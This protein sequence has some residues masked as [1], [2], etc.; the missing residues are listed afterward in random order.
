MCKHRK[1]RFLAYCHEKSLNICSSNLLTVFD[2]KGRTGN[3]EHGEHGW[4]KAGE[5]SYSLLLKSKAV[6]LLAKSYPDSSRAG[7][8]YQL[9][10]FLEF[11]KMGPEEFLGLSDLEIKQCVRR[12]CLQKNSEGS[13]AAGRRVFYVVRRFLELNDREVSFSKS[14]RETLIKRRPKKIARQ[15]IPTREDIYRMTDSYPDK[16]NNQQLRGRAI[17]LCGWQSGVRPSCLCSWTYGMFKDKLWPKPKIPIPI[18]VV[19]YRPPSVT[20]C[21]ED[22]KLS[23]YN[24]NYYYTFL[25]EEATQA[26]KAYL[27]ARIEGGWQ[28]RPEDPV[29]VTEGTVSR[30]K[31]LESRHLLEI[32]KNAAKQIGIDPSSIWTHCLRK[33]FR[34]TLYRG[35]VDPDVAEALMGHKLPGSRGSY[36]DYHDLRFVREEYLR[37]LWGRIDM[38]R[39]RELEEDV[40]KLRREK[41]KLE[42]LTKEVAE[43]R[44]VVRNLLRK[45]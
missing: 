18:K 41:K 29:F 2:L 32:V 33:A 12:A 11:N 1:I 19:A 40:G 5:R 14:Q 42:G 37:G 15:Y 36:F 25:H 43:L 39:I 8:L 23:A 10:W 21:A 44:E 24:V 45:R 34:K 30:G 7:N 9:K 31:P 3:Q 17:I 4:F 28:P 26:L 16:G 6:D 35:G 20:D 38:G 27:D 22:T 13:F